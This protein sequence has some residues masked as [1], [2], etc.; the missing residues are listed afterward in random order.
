M[1]LS[2]EVK[3]LK[4]Q[5]GKI[6]FNNL[7]HFIS[8]A[9]LLCAETRVTF[10]EIKTYLHGKKK[11]EKT[12]KLH[13]PKNLHYFISVGNIDKVKQQRQKEEEKFGKNKIEF[14]DILN[15]SAPEL[16]QKINNTSGVQIYIYIYH[17]DIFW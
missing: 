17:R 7:F 15:F 1:N 2:N 11:V 16:V 14:I 12:F 8:G 6:I 5:S 10:I 13:F 3:R 9:L 4:Q